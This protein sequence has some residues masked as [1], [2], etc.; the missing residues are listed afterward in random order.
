MLLVFDS[1]KAKDLLWGS[2]CCQRYLHFYQQKSKEYNIK[3][4]PV[5]STPSLFS[6]LQGQVGWGF[7][8]AD[9]L[10]GVPALGGALDAM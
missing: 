6:S 4:F 7:R 10:E 3:V 2:A 1:G 5:S 9:K 8:Q